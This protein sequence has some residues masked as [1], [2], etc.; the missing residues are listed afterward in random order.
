[1]RLRAVT[2]F[3]A[4]LFLFAPIADAN[5]FAGL[6]ISNHDLQIAREAYKFS[7]N[8]DWQNARQAARE[9]SDPI[10]YKIILWREFKEARNTSSDDIRNFLAQNKDWPLRDQFNRRI[11]IYTKNP[12]SK[13]SWR[14]IA[15]H[16]R[17]LLEDN[18][19]QEAF[20]SVKGKYKN[21]NGESRSE[22]LWLAGWIALR[23]LKDPNTAEDYFDRQF[24]EAGSPITKA[25]AGYW[26][27]RAYEQ[28]GDKDKA[29]AW[30]TQAARYPT[31]FYGQLAA[32]R[33]DDNYVL[34]LPDYSAPNNI[35]ANN[36]LADDRIR[37]ARILDAL[38]DTQ[39]PRLFLL[40]FLDEDGRTVSDYLLV[41][42][43]AQQTTNYEWA[44][45]AGKKAAQVEVQI[46]H[47]NYPVLMFESEYIE[48]PLMMA[49]IRQESQLN[50]YARS[51][52]GAAGLMQ[53]MPSTAENVAKMIGVDYSYERLFEK[54][55][56]MTL[57]SFYLGKR[58]KDF[59][60]SYIM[61]IASYNAGI[62]NVK[63]WVNRFGDP[64]TMHSLE[65]V[66]DWMEEIP[67]AETRNYVQRVMENLQIYRARINGNRYKLMLYKD[68]FR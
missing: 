14:A 13:D 23:F 12:D 26:A 51:S 7:K 18:H 68:L 62:G 25:R 64:R 8:E 52:A 3:L 20:D 6:G 67:F 42:M 60:G 19:P 58:V 59:G 41:V 5:E 32:L 44:V 39:N 35:D 24:R 37:A 61:A 63:T 11:G 28:G 43:L 29:S 45:M 65:E 1:M 27:G 10:I 57:G 48:K 17:D 21:Y 2:I 49:I 9:A 30:Y 38:G 36:F 40:K 56:N 47:A 33:M 22:A 53:L 34:E 31:Y 15:S 46:P 50:R 66:V 16:A 4:I 55:Y 54:D